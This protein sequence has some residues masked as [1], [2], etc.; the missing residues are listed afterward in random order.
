MVWHEGLLWMSYYAS[1]EGKTAIDPGTSESQLT[2]RSSR[3]LLPAAGFAP[4][5]RESTLD[6]SELEPVR[7][8]IWAS[9]KQQEP[10]R[11]G[12]SCRA[13]ALVSQ[14][15]GGDWRV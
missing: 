4:M 12:G 1:H 7:T 10:Y 3:A 11:C 9:L 2:P 6:D 14:R 8:S 5:F 15:P 13:E